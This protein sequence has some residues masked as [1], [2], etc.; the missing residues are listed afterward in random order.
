ML[1]VCRYRVTSRV[2]ASTRS[3]GCGP[4]ISTKLVSARVAVAPSFGLGLTL[5]PS[6]FLSFNIEYRAF[7]F[8]GGYNRGG[9]DSRGT[10]P[11]AS[12]PD[13]KVNSE[14]RTFKFNQLVFIALGFHFPTTPKVSD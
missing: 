2:A 9:F 11:D 10:G 14:D 8:I 4:A 7:P 13:N 3:S 12:F 1:N 6:N 5:Y